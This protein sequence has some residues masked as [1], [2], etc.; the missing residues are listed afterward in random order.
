[1]PR[2][3]GAGCSRR[4][5]GTGWALAALSLAMLMSSLGTSI[6]NVALPT[7]AEAFAASFQQV[8]WV[9]LAYLLS[10]TTLIVSVGRLADIMGHRRVMLAGI[11]LFTV[12]SLLCGLAPTLPLL[13]AGRALQGA[14]AAVLMALTVAMVRDTVGSERTGSAMGLIGTMSAVGTALGPSLGGV[15][16]AACGWQAI[17]IVNVPFGIAAFWL[18]TRT[19]PADRRKPAGGVRLEF[20]AQCC[21]PGARRLCTRDDGGRGHFAL[22]MR[23]CSRPPH[24]PAGCS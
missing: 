13:I 2:W 21:W 18:A 9:V 14:G 3:T 12:A 22:S 17:F 5:Q 16:L 8:Q 19:L 4:V 10:I 20:R 1:M 23:C 7:L 24:W 15:L 6:A 11:A